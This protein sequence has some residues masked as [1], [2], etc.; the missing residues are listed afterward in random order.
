MVSFFPVTDTAKRTE[1]VCGN[2]SFEAIDGYT[3]E[4]GNDGNVRV[5]DSLGSL[6]RTLSGTEARA[7][8]LCVEHS[9]RR[10]IRG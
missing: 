6:R 8:S 10:I 9:V 3:F 7:L 2:V 1:D 5:Y 4:A